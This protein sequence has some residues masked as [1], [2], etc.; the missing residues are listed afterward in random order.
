MFTKL[1]TAIL[2]S[3]L[4][5]ACSRGGGGGGGGGSSSG[6][7]TVSP[8]QQ[9]PLVVEK[10][11]YFYVVNRDKSTVSKC[12]I[13][14]EKGLLKDCIAT[15]G[16]F[17]DPIGIT[18][19]GDYAYVTNNKKW[20]TSGTITM[21][22]IEK[23]TGVFSN[24]KETPDGV[25]F[26]NIAAITNRNGY[27]YVT[28]YN[29]GVTKCAINSKTG[30]LSGCNFSPTSVKSIGIILANKYFYLTN[31]EKNI[32]EKCVINSDESIGVCSST[33]FTFVKP[34]GIAIYNGLAYVAAEGDS[35]VYKC[36]IKADGTFE[37][38]SATGAD[39]YYS[40]RSINIING[41]AYVTSISSGE[42][43]I[44]AVNANNS[45][46]EDC[47]R[48]TDKNTFA[49]FQEGTAY[50]V[51][52][53]A[54]TIAAATAYLSANTPNK[55]Y[56]CTID[57]SNNSL[58]NCKETGS[59]FNGPTASIVNGSNLYV[60]NKNG[61]SVTKCIIGTDNTLSN[62]SL[63]PINSFS[64]IHDI[65]IVNKYLYFTSYFDNK[66]GRCVFNE[67]AGN[68][69]KCVKALDINHPDSIEF[70][71]KKAYIT[72]GDGAHKAF[73]CDFD[74]ATG[75]ITKCNP[76]GSFKD[77]NSPTLIDIIT[78]TST[79]G[80]F[81]YIYIPNEG[82]FLTRCIISAAG[83]LS[84]CKDAES[85]IKSPYSV[86]YF[87]DKLYVLSRWSGKVSACSINS[88]TG[89]LSECNE[90]LKD[91]PPMGAGSKLHGFTLA[92]FNK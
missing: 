30:T 48:F 74:A 45:N 67:A 66:I 62:C 19:N 63:I 7:I 28:N 36:G 26:N 22:Q 53:N 52:T 16:S 81:S 92:V 84:D 55:V 59:A 13:I 86:K 1:R 39:N 10:T 80:T 25:V 90:V 91:T 73:I 21:C 54:P 33:N 50:Y 8:Q 11:Y 5:V 56:A 2:V 77:G 15:G 70:K 35:K 65:K 38:C 83:D 44:C 88:A 4:A 85:G 68:I 42:I 3:L 76:S 46:L 18:I 64:D 58:K 87:N 29:G 79:K 47:K 72:S 32:V 37:N 14:Q 89:L 61:A 17:S 40:P 27:I 69:E 75:A 12:T 43:T 34:N 24:C 51:Y 20:S 6:D 41:F 78:T 60:G 49:N 71:D 9:K 82:S 31:Y 57:L 23:T